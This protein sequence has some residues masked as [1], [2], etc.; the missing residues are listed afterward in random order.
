MAEALG[1]SRERLRAPLPCF[2]LRS[3]FPP[4]TRGYS[5]PKLGHRRFSPGR[6]EQLLARGWGVQ[7]GGLGRQDTPLS[8][9]RPAP[10]VAPT[11]PTVRSDSAPAH[12]GRDGAHTSSSIRVPRPRPRVARNPL[13]PGD[14]PRPPLGLSGSG[15]CGARTRAAAAGGSSSGGPGCPLRA[16]TGDAAGATHLVVPGGPAT[17]PAL[18]PGRGSWRRRRR[19]LLLQEG[20]ESSIPPQGQLPPDRPYTARELL[21]APL[22]GSVAL[23]PPPPSVAGSPASA[24]RRGGAA[25]KR[26]GLLRRRGPPGVPAGPRR[27]PRGAAADR[28]GQGRGGWRGWEW[29]GWENPGLWKPQRGASVF[30]SVKR[31]EEELEQ[32]EMRAFVIF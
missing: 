5:S 11:S 14:R 16:A 30:S 25:P 27:R 26:R 15:A 1:P 32:L 20:A 18:A 31:E 3:Q 8:G 28:A 12:R 29:E 6:L 23:S 10:R 17:G 2:R 9:L 19:R 7:E 21:P 13:G 22:P 24:R 4:G